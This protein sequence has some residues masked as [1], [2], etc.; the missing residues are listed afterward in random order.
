MRGGSLFLASMAALLGAGLAP[1]LVLSLSMGGFDFVTL[2]VMTVV[3][4]AV[5]V[6]HLLFLGFPLYLFLGAKGP[7]GWGKTALAGFL[8]GGVPLPSLFLFHSVV[9]RGLAEAGG[10]LFPFLWLGGAGLAGALAFRAVY[11]PDL[12][13]T[14]E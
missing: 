8:T 12:G 6:P 10:L 14:A 11:G 5:A 13:G 3:A 1:A 9:D 4:A 2:S 7:V